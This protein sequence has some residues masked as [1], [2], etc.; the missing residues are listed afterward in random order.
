[1]RS[2]G[3]PSVGVKAKQNEFGCR[4]LWIKG[5]ELVGHAL[6]WQE[7]RPLFSS[8]PLTPFAPSQRGQE[9]GC[10]QSHGGGR[11]LQSRLSVG[12]LECDRGS[13]AEQ[14]GEAYLN[15]CRRKGAGHLGV[16]RERIRAPVLGRKER[17]VIW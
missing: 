9:Y 11:G 16:W 17:W 1:M 2:G 4:A 3:N 12:C 6:P 13:E 14:T 5:R 7:L 8:L 10:F 15:I